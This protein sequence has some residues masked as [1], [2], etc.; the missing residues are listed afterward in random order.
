[1]QNDLMAERGNVFYVLSNLNVAESVPVGMVGKMYSALDHMRSAR[2]SSQK[3]AVAEKISV[4]I[5]RLETARRRR[6]DAAEQ[7]IRESLSALA[8][9]WQEAHREVPSEQA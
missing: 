4:A 2:A 9:A 7:S 6:D 3:I 5:R 1:M 8:T